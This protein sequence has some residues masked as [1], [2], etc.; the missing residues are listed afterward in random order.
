MVAVD[1]LN[2]A[3]GF[4]NTRTSITTD[5]LWMGLSNLLRYVKEYLLLPL[6]WRENPSPKTVDDSEI[7]EPLKYDFLLESENVREERLYRPHS[8]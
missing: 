5:E 7:T 4:V 8:M 3:T 1:Q 6:L 2:S